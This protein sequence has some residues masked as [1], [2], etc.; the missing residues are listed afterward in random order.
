[1]IDRKLK[2]KL[3]KIKI[4]KKEDVRYRRKRKKTWRFAVR[5]R[6]TNEINGKHMKNLEDKTASKM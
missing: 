6:G 5:K 2:K 1:M 4:K 3:L